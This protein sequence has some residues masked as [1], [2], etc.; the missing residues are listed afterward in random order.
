MTKRMYYSYMNMVHIGD[1]KGRLPGREG[2]RTAAHEK[3][4]RQE[5]D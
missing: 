2:R 1:A 3:E 4:G 5:D